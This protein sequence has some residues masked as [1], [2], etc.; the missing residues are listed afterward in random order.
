MISFLQYQLYDILSIRSQAATVLPLTTPSHCTGTTLPLLR[1]SYNVQ[2]AT[3][4]KSSYSA[5]V[6]AGGSQGP[7]GEQMLEAVEFVDAPFGGGVQVGLHDR[8]VDQSL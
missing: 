5:G 4:A 6:S 1:M 3:S 2:C 8:E 7:G